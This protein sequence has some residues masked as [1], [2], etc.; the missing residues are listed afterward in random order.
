MYKKS[1]S[2]FLYDEVTDDIVGVMDPDGSEKIFDF[3]NTP[4]GGGFIPT[5]FSPTLVFDGVNKEMIQ[6]AVSGALAFISSGSTAGTQINVCLVANGTNVPTFAANFKEATGSS[7]FDNTN[8]VKNYIQFLY[9]NNKPIY[10]IFQEVGDTGA[11]DTTAPQ[12]S[13]AVVQN[14]SPTI[15]AVTFSEALDQT[16]AQNVGDWA[17]A[18]HTVS[19]VAF[20]GPTLVNLTVNAFVNGEATRTVLYINNAN[21]IKDLANNNA[22]NSSAVNITNNVGAVATAPAQVTGL[23]LGTPT[24]TTQPLT[25]TAPANGGSAI[26]DYRVEFSSNG[27]TTW[28]IFADGTSTA[29]S[30]TVTGLTASTSYVY[31]V[32]AINAIGTGTASATVTGSTTSGISTAFLDF[33]TN[34]ASVTETANGSGFNYAFSSLAGGQFFSHTSNLKLPASTDGYVQAVLSNVIE[35][36][37]IIGFS[38]TNNTTVF[39]SSAFCLYRAQLNAY[40]VVQNGAVIAAINTPRNYVNNDILRV[41]RAGA[42]FFAEVSSDGGTTFTTVHTFAATSSAELFPVLLFQP[43]Q[44]NVLTGSA[45]FVQP[46]ILGGVAV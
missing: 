39:A 32:S 41:R 2:P 6:H 43:Q 20:A 35:A 15:V 3:T 21:R 10:S 42:T 44:S 23:T 18:G 19:N 27:G 28:N 22:A 1:G 38:T 11:S 29:T 46:N 12:L 34:S 33:A 13:S 4:G 37:P 30:A 14:A 31:R 8:N 24:S 5:P 26:T 36:F 25:W 7:G 16:V 17:V 40:A 45:T 9:T